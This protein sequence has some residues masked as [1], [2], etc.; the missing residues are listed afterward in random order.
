[1]LK[2]FTNVYSQCMLFLNTRDTA[3][4][5]GTLLVAINDGNIQVWSHHYMCERYITSFNA[6]HMPG[7]VSKWLK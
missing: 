2:D 3:I 7:D 6:I 5:T 1:M 4:T